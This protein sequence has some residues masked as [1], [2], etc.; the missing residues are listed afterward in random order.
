MME[1]LWE[2]AR[3]AGLLFLLDASEVISHLA[4]FL[5]ERLLSLA[6]IGSVRDHLRCFG[7]DPS[8]HWTS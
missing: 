2:I 6:A 3:H 7:L 4:G 8:N 5:F 1:N